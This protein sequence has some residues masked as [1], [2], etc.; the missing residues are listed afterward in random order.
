MSASI[1][2][3]R[4]AGSRCASLMPKGA[5]E[6]ITFAELA[7]LVVAFR[8]LARS[9]GCRARRPRRHHAGTLPGVLCRDVR[10]H[11]ASAPSPCRC[12][13]CSVPTAS[14]LRTRD[15]APRLL[16]TTP[17]KVAALGIVGR[18]RVVV[19]ADDAFMAA[20]ARLPD[21]YEPRPRPTTWP[22]SSTPPARRGR[23]RLPSNTPI[24]PSV[25]VMN[26]ALY[27]TGIAAWRP[28]LLP[29]LARLGPR[30]VARYAGAA[31]A[32]DRDRRLC[33]QVRCR[34]SAAGLAGL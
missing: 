13:R 33:R 22:S 27:G 9:A 29:V 21:T 34:A 15:C 3:R 26:A 8:A 24:E 31:G 23:C 7:R 19:A 30:P 11:E 1:G 4:R 17:G 16:L 20:L 12:S 25:M 2:T 10:R 14:A 28:L 5:D 6:V 32:G 18:R